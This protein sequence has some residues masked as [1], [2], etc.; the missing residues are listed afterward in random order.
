MGV[1]ITFGAQPEH[2]R[3]K[4]EKHHSLLCGSEQEFLPQLIEVETP[5]FF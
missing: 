3:S 4:N 5:A 1:A 2:E